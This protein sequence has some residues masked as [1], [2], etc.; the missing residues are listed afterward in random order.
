MFNECMNYLE[1]ISQAI[2]AS[3]DVIPIILVKEV[4]ELAIHILNHAPFLFSSVEEV[5]EVNSPSWLFGM[6]ELYKRYSVSVID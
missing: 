6:S 4:Y 1:V 5:T 3:E 2:L